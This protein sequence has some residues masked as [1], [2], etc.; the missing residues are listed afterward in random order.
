MFDQRS[1]YYDLEDLHFRQPDRRPVL[2]KSRRFLPRE[3]T[4]PVLTEVTI[5]DNERPD[6]VAARVLQQPELFWQL[7]DANQVMNPFELTETFGR[8]IRVLM[9]GA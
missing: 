5:L 9:P 6:L 2:Y 7:C 1:R 8:K 3:E 4:R